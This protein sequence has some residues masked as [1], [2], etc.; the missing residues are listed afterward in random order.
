M[1]QFS[2][3]CRFFVSF[4]ILEKQLLHRWKCA[5]MMKTKHRI[6]QPSMTGAFLPSLY[7]NHWHASQ[8]RDWTVD[9]LTVDA[10]CHLK[11]Q[12]FDL[13]NATLQIKYH[14]DHSLISIY[15]PSRRP[16]F[17]SNPILLQRLKIEHKF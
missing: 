16:L 8:Q 3:Q 11:T 12:T 1:I 2:C 5:L 15:V 17:S 4:L 6:D 10:F 14:H 7:V 13:K 9:L